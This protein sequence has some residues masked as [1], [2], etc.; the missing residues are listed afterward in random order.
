MP[1]DEGYFY[2]FFPQQ[3]L[4]SVNPGKSAAYYY[5]FIHRL[6]SERKPV[7]KLLDL[8]L[9]EEYVEDF[10][11]NNKTPYDECQECRK[12]AP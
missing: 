3:M 9:G 7:K 1:A 2:V 8:V 12:A 4:C 6:L 11:D 5:N 10:L